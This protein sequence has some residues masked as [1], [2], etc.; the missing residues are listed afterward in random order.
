MEGDSRS[1]ESY[2]AAN[3]AAWNNSAKY[4]HTNPAWTELTSGFKVPGYSCL[5]EIDT[6]KLRPLVVGKDVAQICCN[7][8]RE[9]LSIKNFGAASCVGFDQ[10]EL[11]IGHANEI[12]E[13]A[14]Q[15][16]RF[17][18]GD[19]YQIS[20]IYNDS[21]DIVIITI[22]VFGWMPDLPRFLSVLTRLLRPNGRL[23]IHEE[24]PVMNMFDPG[25]GRP[26]EITTSYF[27]EQPEA[28]T[29]A[30]VYDGAP[31]DEIEAYF[32][33]FHTLSDVFMACIS[34]GLHIESFQEYPFNI[35]SVEYDIY[36]ASNVALPM[37]YTLVAQKQNRF[38]S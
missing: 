2:V 11:F 25:N 14:G 18:V 37:S 31:A 17:I 8:G 26:L 29:A 9:L 33:F 6:E 3:R 38:L 1:A 13:I 16:C 7:N 34:C 4:H 19:A 35:N 32:W 30:I 12:N 24:H 21:F 10:S 15:D 5:D 20:E 27:R 36:E 22:G 28:G 23:Y